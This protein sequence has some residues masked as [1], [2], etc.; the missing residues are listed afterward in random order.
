MV[1]LDPSPFSPCKKDYTYFVYCIRSNIVQGSAQSGKVREKLPETERVFIAI[2]E[3]YAKLLSIHKNDTKL[4][5]NFDDELVKGG[6][7]FLSN[8]R[9]AGGTT[10]S[11]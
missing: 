7:N 10:V 3:N 5:E 2:F 8:K 6:S 4:I 11:P 1:F 9:P